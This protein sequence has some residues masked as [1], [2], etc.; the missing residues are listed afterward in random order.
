[1]GKKKIET[2]TKILNKNQRMI[3]YGKRYHGL[4]KKAMELSMLCDQE[5]YLTIFDRKREKMVVYSS[6]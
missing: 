6:T 2:F 4:V 3:S 5:I 1:M